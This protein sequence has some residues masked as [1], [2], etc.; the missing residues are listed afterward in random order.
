ML[1]HLRLIC[2]LIICWCHMIAL[3]DTDAELLFQLY[4]FQLAT[5]RH[6]V[7]CLVHRRV[8]SRL[9][10]SIFHDS[11]NLSCFWHHHQVWSCFACYIF[12]SQNAFFWGTSNILLN[13]FS[14]LFPCTI[15]FYPFR[16]VLPLLFFDSASAATKFCCPKTSALRMETG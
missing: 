13:V 10:Q 12:Y 8:C 2:G 6:A 11:F 9:R 15:Y 14:M 7:L 5:Q 16:I 1:L 4:I 3:T